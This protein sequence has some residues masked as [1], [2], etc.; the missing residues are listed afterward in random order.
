MKSYYKESTWIT[1]W[2]WVPFLGT[3]VFLSVVFIFQSV[4]GIVL[5]SKPLPTP[6][7][8]I[9]FVP[10]LLILINFAKLSIKVDSEKVRVGYGVI[11]KTIS[12]KDV[13]SCKPTE[14]KARTYGGVGIRVGVNKSLAFSAY[15]GSAVE[16]ID[17]GAGFLSV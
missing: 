8:I 10:F 7:F 14:A 11:R 17:L 4:L 6:L 5:F 16:I 15:S 9:L 13:M 3:I 12:L 1:P 2:F